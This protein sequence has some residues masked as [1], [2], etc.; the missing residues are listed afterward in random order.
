MSGNADSQEA[1]DFP[2]ATD[3]QLSSEEVKFLAVKPGSTNPDG[4]A[5]PAEGYSAGLGALA[6]AVTPLIVPPDFVSVEITEDTALT[7]AAHNG[8]Q[9]VI[10]AANVTITAAFSDVGDGF[11]C[12]IWNVSGGNVVMGGM[13]NVNGTT[14]LANGAQGWI[15]AAAWSSGNR[16]GWG[17]DST[18]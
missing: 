8:K 2:D 10:S 17:G 11:A 7:S 9:L 3:A 5:S 13:V 1:G 4:S 6:G 18:L 16:V 12:K 15:A 14:R